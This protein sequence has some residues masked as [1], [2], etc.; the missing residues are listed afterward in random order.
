MDQ[1]Q[2]ARSKFTGTL[3]DKSH[4]CDVLTTDCITC[5]CWELNPGAMLSG[6]SHWASQTVGLFVMVKFSP[7][8]SNSSINIIAG[9][10]S[11]ASAKASLTSFAPSP[12]NICTNCGPASFKNVDLV[13]AAHAL[14]SSVFPVPGG[15]YNSTPAIVS[16]HAIKTTQ[17]LFLKP[18]TLP[19]LMVDISLK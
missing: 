18:L 11:L 14:A 12:M 9:C 13:C 4:L 5:Y 16:K 2:L 8:A 1:R 17:T 19:T 7:I 10:F 3:T 15:P 6:Q